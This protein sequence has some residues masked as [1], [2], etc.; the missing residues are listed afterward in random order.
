MTSGQGE[1]RADRLAGAV[2]ALQPQPD[3]DGRGAGGRDALA[4]PSA[5]PRR[6]A[7]TP[8]RRARPTTQPSRAS[9]SGQP[10]VCA[11]SHSRSAAPASQ[12]VAHQAEGQRGVGARQRRDVLV[13]AGRRCRCGS[14]RWPPRA[15]RACC[16]SLHER[17]LVQVRGCR[18]PPGG[19]IS[20]A[21]TMVSGSK[22]TGGRRSSASR[23]SRRPC[24]SSLRSREAPRWANRRGPIVQPCTYPHRAGEVVGQDGLGAVPGRW[25]PA[26]RPRRGR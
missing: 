23:R 11:S 1:D 4:E 5:R 3:A 26:G 8:R 12:H 20:R 18:S 13:A 15:R 19:T 16:A 25:S 7:R 22:P 2:V 10:T 14:D 24:R 17:P 6:R 9:S 21:S